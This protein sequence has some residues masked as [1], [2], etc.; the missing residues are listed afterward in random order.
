MGLTSRCAREEHEGKCAGNDDT[1]VQELE[2]HN[3]QALQDDIRK[4]EMPRRDALVENNNRAQKQM[5]T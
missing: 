5:P 1:E 4:E 2:G 3:A